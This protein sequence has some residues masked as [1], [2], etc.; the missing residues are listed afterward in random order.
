ME[1]GGGGGVGGSSPSPREGESPPSL[2]VRPLVS[3][4]GGPYRPGPLALQSVPRPVEILE[5]E[6]EEEED[7]E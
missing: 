6:E 3:W 1:G 7:E 5:V 2:S 4:A